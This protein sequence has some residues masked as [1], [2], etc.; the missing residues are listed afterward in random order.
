[1]SARP[2]A[3]GRSAGPLTPPWATDVGTH[4]GAGGGGV[5]A[6]AAEALSAAAAQSQQRQQQHAP[7]PPAAYYPPPMAWQPSGPPEA[8]AAVPH[9]SADAAAAALAAVANPVPDALAAAAAPP[10]LHPAMSGPPYAT[11]LPGGGVASCLAASFGPAVASAIAPVA[12]LPSATVGRA[13]PAKHDPA[14]RHAAKRAAAEAQRDAKAR[15]LPCAPALGQLCQPACRSAR[16]S[17]PGLVL[18]RCCGSGSQTRCARQ[19]PPTLR[20]TTRLAGC[21]GGWV[22]QTSVQAALVYVPTLRASHLRCAQAS[23]HRVIASLK[24]SHEAVRAFW[25]L[26]RRMDRE[27]RRTV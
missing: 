25:D 14:A 15:H 22:T 8:P 11:Q 6:A 4:S 5:S 13:A 1:M 17:S 27:A 24:P 2:A 9:T 26:C 20:V 10:P 19:H 7:P 16:G 12:D 18:G 21:L 3:G 23:A